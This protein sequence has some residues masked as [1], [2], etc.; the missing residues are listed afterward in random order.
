MDVYKPNDYKSG[1]KPIW[2]PGCGDYG[3]LNAMLRAFSELDWKFEEIAVISGIGCSSRFPAFVKTY[4]MHGIH[5]RVLP[6]ATGVKLANPALRVVA[7][8]GDGDGFS[9]GGGHFPHTARRNIDL[10][11][12]VMDNSIYG[13][14]KGQ[15]SP[16]SPQGLKAKAAPYGALEQ[17]LNPLLMA[18]AAQATFV[19]RGYAGD[20]KNLV[21]I[22][23]QAFQHPGFAFVQVLSPCV[24]YYNTYDHYKEVTAPLP[25]THDSGDWLGAV[26]LAAETETQYL[27][28]FYR[29]DT[30]P[31]FSQQ[32]QQLRDAVS[33]M[34]LE[35]IIDGF[36]R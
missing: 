24:T 7:V 36:R 10:T 26:K 15:P 30:R 35:K 3:V 13:M 23:V 5:G 33:P 18:L 6:L 22:M 29:D 21:S 8:G 28:I 17:P 9:I 2:C 12:I 27:G 34:T 32:M 31:Y 11:Y 20:F 25:E 19:A 16:T 4:G 14:T 1:I